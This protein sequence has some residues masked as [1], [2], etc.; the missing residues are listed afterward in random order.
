MALCG[1]WELAGGRWGREPAGRSCS[2]VRKSVVWAELGEAL[3]ATWGWSLDA[4]VEGP[5]LGVGVGLPEVGHTAGHMQAACSHRVAWTMGKH[6]P[7]PAE[8]TDFFVFRR[9]GPQPEVWACTPWEDSGRFCVAR[10]ADAGTWPGLTSRSSNLCV[11]LNGQKAYLK[12]RP[13]VSM[14]DACSVAFGGYSLH[15]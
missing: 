15:Y 12:T 10:I 7:A 14:H 13:D 5:Q 3:V 4:D 11:H 9:Q 6:N 2:A 1:L 8:R